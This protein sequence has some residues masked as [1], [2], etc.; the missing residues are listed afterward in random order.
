MNKKYLFVIFVLFFSIVF[1]AQ[2]NNVLQPPQNSPK[3][4]FEPYV[5]KNEPSAPEIPTISYDQIVNDISEQ[6]LKKDLEYLASDQLEGRMS[7]KKGNVLAAKFIREAFHNA[8]LET[9]EQKFMIRR[10]NPGPKNEQGDNFTTNVIGWLKGTDSK[11][12]NEIVVIGAHMDHI[13]Y[14][15]S[16]SRSRIQK[17]HPGAD[18]NASGTVALIQMAKSFA[19]IKNPKRTI[20]FIAFSAEEMG[21]IGSRFYCDNPLFPEDQPDISKHIF[22]LNMDMVGYLGK[23]KYLVEFD[24]A[25]S[26][27]DVKTY[28]ENLRE[29]YAFAKDITIRKT[30][31]SDHASFYNKKVPIAFLHTGLHAHYH[32]PNDTADK[33]NIEG[34]RKITQYAFEL[35]YKIVNSEV[36]PTFNY[37]SF[38]PMD[39]NHDHGHLHF[40]TGAER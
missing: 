24:D 7:G 10:M 37:G 22:M 14:G 11:L 30:G 25:G 21:L 26:S 15:P 3:R 6:E 4:E 9:Q 33:I 31:G 34:L 13:G 27:P 35:S 20:V 18:D 23:A 2:K 8:G 19:K 36:Q 16:M 32:T 17:V 29:K 5:E 28:I 12:K 39:Y 1:F 38:T 40:E